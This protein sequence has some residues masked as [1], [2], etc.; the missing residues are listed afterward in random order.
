MFAASIPNAQ[1]LKGGLASVGIW[2]L[3]DIQSIPVMFHVQHAIV[4]V[5]KRTSASRSFPSGAG[6]SGTRYTIREMHQMKIR[7][8]TA[9]QNTEAEDRMWD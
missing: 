1:C 6:R 9:D 8:A 3:S 4:E 7:K 5:W 2:Y